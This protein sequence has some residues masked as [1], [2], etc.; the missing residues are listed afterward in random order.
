MLCDN[1]TPSWILSHN[2]SHSCP[3][4]LQIGSL[5]STLHR[6]ILGKEKLNLMQRKLSAQL[7][8]PPG[9]CSLNCISYPFVSGMKKIWFW[10][11]KH[12]EVWHQVIWKTTSFQSNL[13]I[14]S[15][16]VCCRSHLPNN[17][18]WKDSDSMPFSAVVP[19]LWNLLSPEVT[20]T[21]FISTF[22][23][24]HKTSFFF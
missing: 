21:P 20:L 17:S 4:H 15:G 5:L 14:S 9:W 13:L 23:K 1:C 7:C 18:I 10:S 16:E 8:V 24:A 12:Y 22:W 2:Q 3:G 6:A 19:S 11:L